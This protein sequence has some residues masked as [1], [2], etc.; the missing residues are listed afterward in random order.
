MRQTIKQMLGLAQQYDD[1]ILWADF[2]GVSH[3]AHVLDFKRESAKLSMGKKYCL[4]PANRVTKKMDDA[5]IEE[6]LAFIGNCK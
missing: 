6:R 1:A 2:Q 4:H 5:A 3:S